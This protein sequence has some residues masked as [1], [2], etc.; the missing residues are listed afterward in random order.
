MA[1]ELL[2][3]DAVLEVLDEV[4]TTLRR[5]GRTLANPSR[6]NMG[7]KQNASTQPG[8]RTQSRQP[9][10]GRNNGASVLSSSLTFTFRRQKRNCM[11]QLGSHVGHG[12]PARAASG[13]CFPPMKDRTVPFNAGGTTCREALHAI[14]V[15]LCSQYLTKHG[16][17]IKNVHSTSSM[18]FMHESRG[19]PSA[20]TIGKNVAKR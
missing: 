9:R 14:L 17:Q 5:L 11:R 13:G 1:K 10:S 7:R 3:T 18:F 15:H 6:M 8:S 4:K 16:L 12:K 19:H 20:F 2:A